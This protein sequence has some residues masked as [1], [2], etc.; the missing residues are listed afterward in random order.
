MIALE[1]G[2]LVGRPR[3]GAWTGG[4]SG[5]AQYLQMIAEESV[6]KVSSPEDNA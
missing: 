5:A 4:Q 6:A 1:S 2:S 3:G